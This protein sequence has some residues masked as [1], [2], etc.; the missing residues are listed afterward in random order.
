MREM[1]AV[2]VSEFKSHMAQLEARGRRGD[3]D[4]KDEVSHGFV[5]VEHMMQLKAWGA[6]C[7]IKQVPQRRNVPPTHLAAPDPLNL[8]APSP[9]PPPN[10]SVQL[11]V[12]QCCWALL[13]RLPRALWYR[14]ATLDPEGPPGAWADSPLLPDGTASTAGL[15]GGTAGTAELDTR[16]LRELLRHDKVTFRERLGQQVSSLSLSLSLSSQFLLLLEGGI[17]HVPCVSCAAAPQFALTLRHLLSQLFEYSH[18]STYSLV[19][20]NESSQMPLQYSHLSTFSL[21]LAPCSTTSG[22]R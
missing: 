1:T 6:M 21:Q 7:S 2:P 11:K 16:L 14:H 17:G 13:A 4:A 10:L 18:L 20:Y 22:W 19:Q 9:P 15:P 8:A 3:Q 12:V 5:I